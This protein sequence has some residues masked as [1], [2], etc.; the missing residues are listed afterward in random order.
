VTSMKLWIILIHSYPSRT[1]N[2]LE[3]SL[4][5]LAY[6]CSSC[7]FQLW[8]VCFEIFF[9]EHHTLIFLL[10]QLPLNFR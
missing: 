1:H 7:T 5:Q 3:S 9:S 2:T 10:T 6:I 4:M 8:S